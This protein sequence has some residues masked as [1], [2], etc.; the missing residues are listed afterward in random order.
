MGRKDI[1][2]YDNRSIENVLKESFSTRK[3]K[4]KLSKQRHIL[5]KIKSSSGVVTH[6][7]ESILLEVSKFYA[8]LYS[9][10]RE[11]ETSRCK[12]GNEWLERARANDD[13][14][15]ILESEVTSAIR[16]LKNC[17]VTMT[18]DIE[19]EVLKTLAAAIVPPLTDIFN[20]IVS[21]QI[22]PRQWSVSEII[23]LFKNGDR[24][25]IN[26]YRPI[27]LASIISEVS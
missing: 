26:N 4:R 6:D 16:N 14:A 25:D 20:E 22:T 17:K 24:S 27:S 15:T 19:I 18:E 1:R 13:I 2:D 11:Y 21:S 5:P 10:P 12:E 9:D 7:R 8:K 23:L 3:L